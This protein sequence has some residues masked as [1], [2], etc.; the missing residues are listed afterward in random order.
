MISR[1]RWERRQLSRLRDER[2]RLTRLH[3]ELRALARS[4]HDYEPHD[5][6]DDEAAIQADAIERRLIAAEEALERIGS[7]TYGRCT[8]CASQ[9]ADER[10]EALPAAA[11][12]R[13]CAG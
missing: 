6:T 8:G 5:I 2:E 11:L 13:G 3:E 1:P 7:G 9:I 12:C 10:L 4:R